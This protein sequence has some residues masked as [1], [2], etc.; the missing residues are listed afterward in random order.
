MSIKRYKNLIGLCACEG[1]RNRFINCITIRF[2]KKGG[3]IVKAPFNIRRF[4]CCE[5]HTWA[6]EKAIV[7]AGGV[8]EDGN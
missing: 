2:E 1:C 6:L 3:K 5:D 8:R 7:S 4:W